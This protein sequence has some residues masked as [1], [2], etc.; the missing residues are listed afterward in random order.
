MQQDFAKALHW[1][2]LAAE[3]GSAEAQ[4]RLAYQYAL[5]L[6]VDADYALTLLQ[7]DPARSGYLLK[8]RITEMAVLAGAIERVGRGETVLDPELVE[9]LLHRPAMRSQLEELTAREREVL[10][11]LAEGLTDRGIAERL[12]LTPKTVETH[13]R[14]ILQK[15]NLPS[16]TLYNRRV[17]AVLTYMRESAG[18]TDPG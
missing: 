18:V 15:L 16:D 7:S 13:V 4:G 6:G 12:W 10:A 9:L 1:N 11:L 14:H 5:G 2:A 3:A 17:L 8:D